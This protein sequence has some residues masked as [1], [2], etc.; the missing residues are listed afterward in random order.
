MKRLLV[1]ALAGLL[2]VSVFSAPAEAGG[3]IVRVM[4]RNQY[5]G[6]GLTPFELHNFH[7]NR[8]EIPLLSADA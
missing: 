5:R 1:L 6:A 7:K 4:T 8:C 3:D 2:L